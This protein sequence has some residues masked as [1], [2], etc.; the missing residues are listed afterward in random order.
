M[1]EKES[2]STERRMENLRL[3]KKQYAKESKPER[4]LAADTP[5]G[6]RTTPPLPVER[7]ASRIR[8][9]FD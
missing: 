4:K 5:R 1:P 3:A 9:L 2:M 8:R 7:Q 6:E